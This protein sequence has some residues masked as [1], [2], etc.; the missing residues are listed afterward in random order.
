MDAPVL[1]Y[2]KICLTLVSGGGILAPNVPPVP[3]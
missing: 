1:F 3:S 2:L